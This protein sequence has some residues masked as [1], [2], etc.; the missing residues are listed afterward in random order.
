MKILQLITRSELRGAEVFA[1]QLSER[2]AERG[3][4]VTLAA[5]YSPFSGGIPLNTQGVNRVELEG[6]KKGHI[7]PKLLYRLIRLCRELRPD[8]VQA[9]AFHALKYIA[10]AKKLKQYSGAIVYR[11]ISISSRWITRKG[12]RA[13]GK[14]LLRSADSISSVSESGNQD[15]C[16]TYRLPPKM[17]A[18]MHQGIDIPLTLPRE[19]IRK[20]ISQ[21]IGCKIDDPLLFHIGGFTEE[22]NHAGLLNAFFQ[23]QEQQPRAQLLLCGEGPL[24]SSVK[25]EVEERRLDKHVHLL[26]AREDIRDL[27]IGADLMLLSSKVEGI[28][29]VIL[30]ASVRKVPSIAT[31]VGGVSEAVQNGQTGILVAPDD[32]D[33]LA[34]E[35]CKLIADPQK[36]QQMG[37]AAKVLITERHSMEKCVDLHENLYQS[38]TSTRSIVDT[39]Q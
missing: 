29:A 16:E 20:T 21:L 28:P 35:A 5:L 25:K 15:F 38:L 10:L 24:F 13:W 8:V 9:N 12:Q 32:M 22:K 17:V 3:H 2:L 19:A 34:K 36:R 33:K 14:W 39:E 1:A 23:I 18:T 4:D 30:E 27:L 7:E 37:K 11:N 26:G 31:N 6:K